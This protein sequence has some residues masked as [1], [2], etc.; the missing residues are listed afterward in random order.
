MVSVN[1]WLLRKARGVTASG[2]PFIKN[3]KIG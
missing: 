1:V 2:F 3:V